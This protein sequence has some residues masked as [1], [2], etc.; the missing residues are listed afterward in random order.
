MKQIKKLNL[1]IVFILGLLIVSLTANYAFE[2][3]STPSDIAVI[4][5]VIALVLVA[6]AGYWLIQLL[7]KL[8]K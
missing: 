8:I 3:L 6:N 4:A 1:W 7:K 2:W 5:G